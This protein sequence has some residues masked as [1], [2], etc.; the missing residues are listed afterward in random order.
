MLG[1]F[2]SKL[3]K[4][5]EE[6]RPPVQDE[7]HVSVPVSEDTQP[8]D[9]DRQIKEGGAATFPADRRKR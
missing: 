8:P 4:K 6:A 9:P 1:W 2:K 3:R 5:E 7:E